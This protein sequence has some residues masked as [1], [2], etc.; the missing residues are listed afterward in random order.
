MSDEAGTRPPDREPAPDGPTD[1]ATP[2][3][4][5]VPAVTSHA[6]VGRLSARSTFV[7]MGMLSVVTLVLGVLREF[8]IAR[9]LR[10]S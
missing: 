5:A 3:D 7:W 6:D 10:A 1:P 2:T 4:A 9:D 8:V